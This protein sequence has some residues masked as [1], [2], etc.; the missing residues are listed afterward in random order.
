MNANEWVVTDLAAAV[1]KRVVTRVRRQ[2]Q[3]MRE[4]M[5]GGDD[6][7]LANLW[8]EICVQ[9]QFEESIFSNMYLDIIEQ[10]VLEAIRR[11]PR[12]ELEAVWLQTDAGMDWLDEEE[13]GERRAGFGSDEVTTYLQQQVLDLAANW[14]NARIR[15]DL[16]G[17]YDES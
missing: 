17:P 16:E 4:G 5:Q 13:N 6:S 2:L 3:G 11:L 14:S 8:D 7:P 15:E 12:Y 9:V 1:S 10:L